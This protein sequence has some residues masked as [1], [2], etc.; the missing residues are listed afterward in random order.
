MGRE[1]AQSRL[2]L[3]CGRSDRWDPGGLLDHS[4]A[5]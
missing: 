2:R 1:L 5:G 4:R 3:A